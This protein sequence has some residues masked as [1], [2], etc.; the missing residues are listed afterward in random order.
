MPKAQNKVT[1]SHTLF[2]VSCGNCTALYYKLCHCNMYDNHILQKSPK[3]QSMFNMK[4]AIRN[5]S[6]INATCD[7]FALGTKTFIV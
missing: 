1:I 2:S 7:M 3:A 4:N 5:T 6:T